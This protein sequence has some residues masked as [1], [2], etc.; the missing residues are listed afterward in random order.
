MK[1]QISVIIPCFNS[2]KYI[3]RNFIKVN[4]KIKK[5]FKN[6]E[7]IFI[8][9]GSVDNTFKRLKNI[10]SK[11]K[12]IKIIN[13]NI[14]QG[15]SYA[16]R[17]GIKITKGKKIL[18]YDSDIPYFF[19]LEKLI[20][21]LKKNHLVIISRREKR[22][23]IS[24][25]E[26][27]I[28]NFLRNLIGNI[29]SIANYYLFNIKVKDTQAGLKGFTNFESLKKKKFISK[30]FFLDIEIINFFEKKNI[31]PLNIPVSYVL[32]NNKSTISLVNIKNNFAILKEYFKVINNT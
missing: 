26:N 20:L 15:K 16:I 28:Y 7:Y 6:I 22:S 13:F 10:K 9:D 18:L 32:R 4:N 1:Y 30:K 29:I 31:A 14:N 17:Q 24:I 2:E 3:F 8:N 27:Y 25:K 19:Y 21:K 11:F 12:N 23:K 5:H